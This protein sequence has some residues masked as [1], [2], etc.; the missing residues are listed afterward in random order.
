M[1]RYVPT[2]EMRWNAVDSMRGVAVSQG[3]VMSQ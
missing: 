2:T 3:S 1:L